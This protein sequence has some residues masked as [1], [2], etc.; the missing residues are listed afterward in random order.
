MPPASCGMVQARCQV[1]TDPRR[2][3]C[4]EQPSASRRR[5]KLLHGPRRSALSRAN[6]HRPGVQ[7]LPVARHSQEAR[8]ACKLQ[9]SESVLTLG[10]SVMFA[11]TAGW[12]S[13]V[14]PAG[15]TR[16]TLRETAAQPAFAYRCVGICPGSRRDG[17][18][19][20]DEGLLKR[21]GVRESLKLS[22]CARTRDGHCKRGTFAPKPPLVAGG[23]R[24]SAWGFFLVP[25]FPGIVAWHLFREFL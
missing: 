14:L 19:P 13:Y 22:R 5:L 20:D 16:R 21:A 25:V 12:K 1:P 23:A 7:L 2:S 9:R 24:G 3:G 8:T 17:D 4:C 18:C 15:E 6:L 10:V 11:P